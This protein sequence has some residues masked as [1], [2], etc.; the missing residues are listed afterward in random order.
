[1]SP[2]SRSG[3]GLH[4]SA[5]PRHGGRRGD[6]SGGGLAWWQVLTGLIAMGVLA[7]A[8]LLAQ[9]AAHD[10]EQVVTSGAR[11]MVCPALAARG[12]L[13]T[14]AASGQ[15]QL[16]ALGSASQTLGG[17]RS[18]GAG[19][20]SAGWL[21]QP[22]AQNQPVGG[23][24]VRG[25]N[26]QWAACQ[27]AESQSF[28][29]VTDAAHVELVLVNPDPLSVS[30]NLTFHTRTGVATVAGARGLVVQPYASRVVPLS[31]VAPAGPTGIEVQTDSGRVLALARPVTTG[32]P[33]AQSA[34]VSAT[35]TLLAG[36]P[37]GTSRTQLMVTNPGSRDA[38]V[39]VDGLTQSGRVP[40]AGAQD[41]VV[42]AGTTKSL[43]LTASVAKERMALLIGSSGSAVVVSA[44][45]HDG[46]PLQIPATD[47]ARHLVGISPDAGQLTLANPGRSSV[48][49]QVTRIRG[50]QS[51]TT[52][53]VV[54]AGSSVSSA[55]D[56]GTIVDLDASAP[57]GASVVLGKS[58]SPQ[59]VAPLVQ[60]G[61][62][63]TL[64]L[65]TDQHLR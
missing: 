1:M 36:Q 42:P 39:S 51:T 52:R 23:V 19:A 31:I 40:L 48:T 43:D 46:R 58:G 22:V 61:G 3:D 29:N 16:A 11:S 32:T 53:V 17:L 65:V 28:V 27:E 41:V 33:G 7:A 14:G 25:S 45:V 18:T 13:V 44:Q 34:Q 60:S 8:A 50:G 37:Q 5:T 55:V 59:A 2:T 38:T 64:G 9:P 56:A 21:L 20:G 54:P 24:L 4:Q 26:A 63:G 10:E 47:T 30:V 35:T 57:L 6:P 49:A 12:S 15:Y 62:Q